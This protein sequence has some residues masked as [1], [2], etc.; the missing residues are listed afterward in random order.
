M[1][2]LRLGKEMYLETYILTD[3]IAIYF[4][5]V[6]ESRQLEICSRVLREFIQL[7]TACVLR[8]R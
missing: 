6:K 4:G 5:Y 1:I 8:D 3:F 2:R 7:N